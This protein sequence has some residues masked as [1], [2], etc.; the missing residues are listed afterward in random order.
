MLHQ[1]DLKWIA[2]TSTEL[3]TV[4]Q[5]IARYADL[6]KRQRGDHDYIDQLNQQVEIATQTAQALLNRVMSRILENTSGRTPSPSVPGATSSAPAVELAGKT[7]E[8]TEVRAPGIS[9]QIAILNPDGARELVLIIDDEP[10]I[11]EFASTILAE[12]GYKVIVARDGFEALKIFQQMHRQ[13]GLII[14][15]F[16]LPVMD[17][18]AVFEEL[19]ALNPSVNVV[20]SGG[21]AEQNKIGAILAQGLR[22]FIPKPYTPEKLLEQVRSALD[23]SRRPIR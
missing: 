7:E 20:L 2:K 3:N 4:L 21:L 6:A 15:D 12:E 9:P 18:D 22:G 13:I 23:A 11:A 5:Q 14:L 19:K 17:G 1:D 10:E 8:S 16:F